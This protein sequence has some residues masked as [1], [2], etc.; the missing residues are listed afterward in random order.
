MVK[1]GMV[2]S[3]LVGANLEPERPMSKREKAKLKQEKREQRENA[4][5]QAEKRPRTQ[6]RWLADER[7]LSALPKH[8][9]AAPGQPAG[10]AKAGKPAQP[11]ADSGAGRKMKKKLQVQA[12]KRMKKQEKKVLGQQKAHKEAAKA[13]SGKAKGSAAS[14]EAT[15]LVANC[16]KGAASQQQLLSLVA[17][18]ITAEP[19]KELKLF[20]VF[21]ELHHKGDD[22]RTR[23]LALLS[24]V[25]VFRDLV[26]GYRVREPTEQENDVVKSKAVMVVEQ[27]EMSLLQKYR[28]LL[29]MLEAGMKSAPAVVAPALAALIRTASD[30]NYRQRL[31]GTAVKHAS[32]PAPIVRKTCADG[33]RDMIE[34]DSRLEA[35]RE[36]VLAIGKIAQQASRRNQGKKEDADENGGSQGGLACELVEVLLSLPVGKA[37]SAALL[38][39]S[40]PEFADDE[41]KKAV[42]EASITHDREKMHKAETELLTETFIVYLRILRQRHV[43]DRRLIASVLTGLARWGQLVNIELLLEILAEL[44]GA[45]MDAVTRSDELVA[46]QGL[47]CALVL[48]SGPA[49][50]LMTDVTWLADAFKNAL[51][52]ALPS[53]HSTH[54]ECAVWPPPRCYRFDGECLHS[55]VTEMQN[56]LETESVPALVLRCLDAALKCPQAYGRASDAA[57][58]QLIE[59]LCALA[60]TADAHVGMTFLREAA[61]LLRK[62]Y[63]LHTLLDV[64]GGLFGLGGIADH[65]VTVVWYLQP[66]AF[67][68]APE[69]AAASKHLAAYAQRRNNVPEIFPFRDG[70]ARL[71][72]EVGEHIAALATAP[73]PKPRAKSRPGRSAL[74]SIL[75]E[76]ELRKACGC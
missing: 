34:Q 9:G 48:M 64:E 6:E 61:L 26:P 38:S 18:R 10:A 54:S 60:L 46:L 28:Q 16:K 35:S 1:R 63:R 51:T 70:N 15:T 65:L 72:L 17:E 12:A 47:N 59:Q 62:H 33:L 40:M 7:K 25:A 68:L 11:E 30:F 55:S 71:I 14:P 69:S 20:D 8:G 2:P 29:P 49:Q 5:L 36:V 75:S 43:H 58:A 50:A 42:R 52:L 41:T 44:K 74:V 73:R 56:S 22:A 24:A 67:G 27:F 57:L 3:F 32:H 39:Q 21:F 53:L 13:L 4:E 31:I 76:T 23:H 66:L 19:E 37:E 45:V